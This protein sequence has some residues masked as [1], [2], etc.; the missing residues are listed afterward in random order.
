MSTTLEQ[1][2]LKFLGLGNKSYF[3]FGGQGTMPR[4]ALKAIFH[5][6]EYIQQQG[7]FC[8]EVNDWVEKKVITTRRA[9]AQELGTTPATITLTENVTAGCNIALWGIDWQPGDHILTT[10]CEH[11]GVMGAIQE[12]SHRFK[13]EFSTCSILPTLNQ[14]NAIAVIEENLRPNTRLVV[15]SHL[16]WNTGQVLPLAE[17]V[18][19]CHHHPRGI[20]V[21]V[22]AAQS[23]GCLP[24]NLSALGAD[25]YAFTGHKWLCGPAGV[26]GLYVRPEALET[27]RPTFVGWRAVITDE[28]CQPI[29]W[30]PDG[31]R[32]EV[33]TSAYPQYAGL[34]AAIA[35]HQKWGNA[36]QRYEKIC[37]LSAYLWQGLS[38]IPGI[39]C[40][41][42]SPPQAGLVSFQIANIDH[43]KFVAALEKRGFLLRT[44]VYPDCIR[45]CVHYF[46]SPA[47]IER[48]I[49]AI[50]SLANAGGLEQ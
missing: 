5:A 24:L 39:K 30:K 35:L 42:N 1:H 28:N 8:Q 29:G 48:L 43:Q 2:R 46:T 21:L 13:L 47:E 11:P 31:R 9:I 45:A 23:A 25:F 17:I 10:D 33:A 12:V 49:E 40:L 7:P 19:L 14:S 18:Q 50:R 37:Q 20:Q 3:N 15:L 41:S 38:Q 6:Y 22:D 44:I 36:Q 27:L 34:E 26:G 32:F 4:V 16:L